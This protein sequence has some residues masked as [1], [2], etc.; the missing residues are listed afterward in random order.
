MILL[1]KNEMKDVKEKRQIDKK[2]LS[3]I[4]LNLSIV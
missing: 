3:Q 1:Y 2:H 4:A